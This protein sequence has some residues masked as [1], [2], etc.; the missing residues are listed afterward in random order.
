VREGA[1]GERDMERED[2]FGGAGA[3]ALMDLKMLR[4]ADA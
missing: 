1:S 4:S 2:S 3:G